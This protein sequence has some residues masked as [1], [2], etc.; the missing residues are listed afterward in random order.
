MPAQCVHDAASRRWVVAQIGAREHYA[1]PRYLHRHGALAH[2][3]T[4]AWCK[5]FRGLLMRGPAQ[6][7][8]LAMRYHP[9]L[10]GTPVTPLPLPAL[11]R[12]VTMKRSAG[13]LSLAEISDL[14]LEI[15]RIFG[16]A[17]VQAIQRR[18]T[19]HDGA[20]FFGFSTGS[21]EIIRLFN[22]YGLPTVIDQIN[23]GPPEE[24]IVEAEM[25]RWP[26]WALNDGRSSE[27]FWAR[28]R[29][30]WREADVV[31]VNSDWSRKCLIRCGVPREKI[32]LV[33]LAYEPSGA[34]TRSAVGSQPTL[35]VLW[36]GSVILRKG[37]QYLM[38]AAHLLRNERIEFTIAGPLGITAEAM[39]TAP[40]NMRFIGKVSRDRIEAIYG[41]SDV[42][43]LPTLSDGFAITQIEAMA[44]GLPVIATPCCG[45]V[46]DHAVDGLI[47]PPADGAALAEAIVSLHRDRNRL[48]ALAAAT[49]EK[50]QGFSM[51]RCFEAF[52]MAVARIRGAA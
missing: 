39:A 3:Y 20:G 48:R 43:V 12:T 32:A 31:V 13:A 26:G 15:G 45:A 11:L 49:G 10:R 5:S 19:L 51:D 17:V 22:G 8:A 36:L 37:I 4:D 25:V 18:G 16:R 7:R 42:F 24:D 33:P 38:E 9:D 21:L 52:T 14:D 30:E 2:L 23:P 28:H 35:R 40:P 50:V 27:A 41:A 47:V 6:V 46:V 34:T 29:E 44:H 1:V